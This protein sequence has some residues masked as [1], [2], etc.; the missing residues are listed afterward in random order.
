VILGLILAYMVQQGGHYAEVVPLEKGK[1]APDFALKDMEGRERRLSDF[2]G[3]LVFLN[4]WATWCPP[5]RDEMP[6]ME[7]LH[8]RMQGRPFKMLAVSLDTDAETANRYIQ[9]NGFTFTALV[10]HQ[11]KA[12]SL[13][14]TTGVP[15]TFLIGSDGTLLLKVIGPDNWS[16]PENVSVIERLLPPSSRQKG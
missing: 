6:S 5:C 16:S 4:F 13:Y 10:D 2:R 9:Q 7:R 12:A 11:Q 1:P 3:Q 8:Q 15:E 14:N